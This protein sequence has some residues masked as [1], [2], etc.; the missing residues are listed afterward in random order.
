MERNWSVG[1]ANGS[2]ASS[3]GRGEAWS[4]WAFGGVLSGMYVA[5]VTG[6][7]YTL[8][9]LW[10]S[11]GCSGGAAL[12]G[13]IANLAL[14]DL[15]YLCSIPFIV[16]TAWARDWHFGELGC[17]LLLS[18]DLLTMHASI[19]TLTGMC[20]ERYLAVTRP[21]AARRR[22]RRRPGATACA[23]WALALL[24]A[25]PMMLM[26]SLRRGG[27]GKRLCAPTWSRAAYRLYL[28]AL[29]STSILAPGLL[30]GCLYGRLAATYLESQRNP[31]CRKAPRRSPRQK[32]LVLVFAIVLVFWAC[33]LPF[34]IWQLLP[35]YHGALR[36]PPHTAR[37]IN[38][39]VTCLT[40]SNSCINPFLYTLLTRNSRRDL[41]HRHTGC[42]RFT[43]AFRG[44]GAHRHCS[45]RPPTS[46]GTHYE[47]GSQ[48][49]SMAALR[50][51]Q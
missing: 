29:F 22:P 37:C 19:F 39:L 38:Y 6:N 34:W 32:V 4:A 42:Y 18:L 30:I 8:A 47:S 46:S 50:D 1:A 28:T 16:G 40:Y 17:R 10:R 9:L 24:L 36:L 13:S 23:V 15:L 35:L 41:R 7:V 21:L 12:S 5:G 43:S 31:P 45:W 27:D 14:A 26:V 51:C 33:F 25:L 11:G 20:A 48:V 3:W 49:L 2:G 44:R